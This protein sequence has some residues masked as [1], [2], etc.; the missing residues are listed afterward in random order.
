MAERS[1]F[2]VDEW[3]HCYNRGVDKRTVFE[4]AGDYNRFLLLLYLG[5]GSTPLHLAN[6]KDNN[7]R[8]VIEDETLERGE[9]LVEIGAYS[10]MPNHF[11]FA[12]KEILEGGITTF[13]QRIFTAFTMYFN[14]KY[15][16]TGALFAGPFKSRH[17]ADD[18]YLKH[19]ISYQHLNAAELFEPRWKEGLGDLRNIEQQL[20]AYPYSSLHDF[21]GHQRPERRILGDSIFEMYDSIPTLTEIIEEAHIYYTEHSENRF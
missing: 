18:R 7:I 20:V 2:G 17:V 12:L 10:L 3:Y 6:L 13:M 19:L 4:D 5:N 11:H 1:P 14:K 9:P 8:A 21:L 15:E 16:R